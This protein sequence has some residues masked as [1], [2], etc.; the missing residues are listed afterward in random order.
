MW[1]E[2]ILLSERPGEGAA[3]I[4]VWNDPGNFSPRPKLLTAHGVCGFGGFRY[5]KQ[6]PAQ[7]AAAAPARS[8]VGAWA[9]RAPALRTARC[10]S[11]RMFGPVT[12]A[13]RLAFC[14]P[15]KALS[16]G[17]QGLR[18]RFVKQPG[19]AGMSRFR[20]NCWEDD[21]PSL[22]RL[23]DGSL[24]CPTLRSR[25]S[26]AGELPPVPHYATGAPDAPWWDIG[27]QLAAWHPAL[28]RRCFGPCVP[29]ALQ[30]VP[31]E[32]ADNKPL[33]ASEVRLLLRA[34]DGARLPPGG[35]LMLQPCC[36]HPSFA[37]EWQWA[38][39]EAPVPCLRPTELSADG[40]T[41]V[42]AFDAYKLERAARQADRFWNRSQYTS[43]R[44]KDPKEGIHRVVFLY[45]PHP[46][47]KLGYKLRKAVSRGW[48]D[49]RLPLV[50]LEVAQLH[51][52]SSLVEY[53]FAHIHRNVAEPAADG[54]EPPFGFA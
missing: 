16:G 10:A 33:R 8:S 47:P 49:D 37:K 36:T 11:R 42:L 32:E 21:M 46:R 2:A 30:L 48:F 6:Q 51:M 29:Q 35:M 24:G 38:W 27:L 50:A 53:S 43:L 45:A 39:H 20:M 22:V 54:V 52:F 1:T 14:A 4:R 5:T 44:F 7:G 12:C 41:G 26:S 28:A 40:T 31:Y 25:L 15:E 18:N 3:Y 9:A 34:V 17:S 19:R 13:W 23:P